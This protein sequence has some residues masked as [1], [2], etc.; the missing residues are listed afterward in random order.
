M[1]IEF[2]VQTDAGDVEEANAYID[3]D[4]FKQYFENVGNDKAAELE[5]EKIQTSI[6]QATAYV[7]VMFAFK[8]EK[9]NG[10]SQS[11]EFPRDCFDGLPTKF[12]NAVAE[13]ALRASVRPLSPDP[14]TDASGQKVA[15]YRKK[16]GPLEKAYS[17][18]PGSFTAMQSYPLADA[19]LREYL[20]AS[21]ALTTVRV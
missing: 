4:Y 16:I 20:A 5:D 8:G 3:L 6:I 12:K 15:S 17:Y 18:E 1:A 2:E 19:M 21:F 7:D 9:L 13:Y 14:V 11:T 10:D